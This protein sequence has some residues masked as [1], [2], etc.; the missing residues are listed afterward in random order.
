MVV[1]DKRKSLKANF[2]R[3][4]KGL[5]FGGSFY[6]GFAFLAPALRRKQNILHPQIFLIV[7]SE[8]SKMYFLK[9]VIMLQWFLCTID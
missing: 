5:Q 7:K 4:E 1:T 8:Y 3:R 2:M 9:I 6:I